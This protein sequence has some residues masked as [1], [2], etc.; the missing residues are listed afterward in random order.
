MSVVRYYLNVAR[1]VCES[2]MRKNP[3]LTQNVSVSA[4]YEEIADNRLCLAI[5]RFVVERNLQI[6]NKIA[7]IN[8]EQNRYGSINQAQEKKLD[9]LCSSLAQMQKILDF[10]RVFSHPTE[11]QRD[12]NDSDDEQLKTLLQTMFFLFLTHCQALRE[13]VC[14]KKSRYRLTQ[15]QAFSRSFGTVDFFSH[16]VSLT[17]LYIAFELDERQYVQRIRLLL[18]TGTTLYV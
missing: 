15:H 11:E 7:E 4:V 17:K 3:L 8:D 10:L 9:V 13:V 18:R 14:A 16:L 1:T 6:T 5:D 12:N 2:E